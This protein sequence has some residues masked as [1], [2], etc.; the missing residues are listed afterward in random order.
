MASTDTVELRCC[1]YNA[2]LLRAARLPL[3]GRPRYLHSA[4]AV[5]ARA[6]E[7][8]DRLAGR[9]VAALL[10]RSLA[11]MNTVL[12]SINYALMILIP[13][14]V[15]IFI[16]RRTDAPPLPES[17]RPAGQRQGGGVFFWGAAG[18]GTAVPL[19]RSRFPPQP[20]ERVPFGRGRGKSPVFILI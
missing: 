5:D 13:I 12:L 8:G 14:V 2:F 17:H 10:T 16:R 20:G 19:W 18:G 3:P 7:L 4:P 9:Y 6:R 1:F 15:A 11:L